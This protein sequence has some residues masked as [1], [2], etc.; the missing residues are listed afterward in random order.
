MNKSVAVKQSSVAVG[1]IFVSNLNSS[2]VIESIF[3]DE[4]NHELAIFVKL[5]VQLV[6]T[7]DGM[8]HSLKFH[9]NLSRFAVSW[10][11]DADF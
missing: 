11:G 9:E 5:P 3:R 4:L 1:S 10:L 7:F 2:F 6:L 8:L